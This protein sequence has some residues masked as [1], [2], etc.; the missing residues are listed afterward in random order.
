VLSGIIF[1]T[2]P[3]FF[4]KDNEKGEPKKEMTKGIEAPASPSNIFEKA[5]PV[6]APLPIADYEKSF[7]IGRDK[8]R[9]DTRSNSITQ[10]EKSVL[11]TSSFEREKPLKKKV[12]ASTPDA[13]D[14]YQA[15]TRLGEKRQQPEDKEKQLALEKS[16]SVSTS[17]E[18][19]RDSRFIANDD[20]TVL[21]KKTNLMWA[22]KDN[23]SNINWTN[24]KSYCENYRG[25]GYTDW[26]MP[27]QDEL[28]GLYDYNKSKKKV[29]CVTYPAHVATDLI[30][31]T[32][33]WVWASENSAAV[34]RDFSFGESLG[35]WNSVSSENFF[36]ALPVRSAK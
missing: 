15:A 12:P 9:D 28:A 7:K 5:I 34:A 36:R 11:I 3:I 35:S 23:G 26:R 4:S 21:D 27:T 22:A 25:G 18:T 32:C 29:E 2:Y 13:D 16:P 33:L 8:P 31:L 19:R 24:A 20:G 10:N 30:H 6:T 1:L 14:R 17:K